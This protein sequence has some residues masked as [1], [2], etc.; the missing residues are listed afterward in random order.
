MGFLIDVAHKIKA[1]HPD[2]ESDYKI[3]FSVPSERGDALIRKT[4]RAYP[5]YTIRSE[6]LQ[7]LFYN[8]PE[9]LQQ[10]YREREVLRKK[11]SILFTIGYE[12]R[13]LEAFLNVLLKNDVRVLCD[14][15]K[16]PFSRK[17][18]FSKEKLEQATQGIKVKY[19]DFSTLGI[20][21]DKR[22]ELDTVDDYNILFANY[23]KT[24]PSREKELHRLYSIFQEDG[25][26]ALMCFEKEPQMC[27]RHV[28]R[29]YLCSTYPIR[30]V[31]L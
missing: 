17:F 21:S 29:D 15:R 19:A 16:N 5:Y 7:R 23:Q 22:K 25:R 11:D 9:E 31:D 14:V 13:T 1:A 30:S 10:L 24:L 8:S 20:E 27:H 4:Y 6:I 26:I 3:D 2:S 12:G 18:G 28:I